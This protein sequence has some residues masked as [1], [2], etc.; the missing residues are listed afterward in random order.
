MFPGNLFACAKMDTDLENEMMDEQDE[1]D[2]H[3]LDDDCEDMAGNAS[4]E[5]ANDAAEL[6]DSNFVFKRLLRK[7]AGQSKEHCAKEERNA[8]IKKV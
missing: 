2:E 8:T 5:E 4:N 3:L 7:Q 1:Q 6:D